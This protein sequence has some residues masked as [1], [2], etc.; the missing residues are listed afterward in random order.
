MSLS[1][2]SPH[3]YPQTLSTLPLFI[4]TFHTSTPAVWTT[5]RSWEES[6]CDED[7]EEDEEEEEEEEEEEGR[8]D[9]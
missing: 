1:P 4:D 7:E 5:Q 3:A 9:L 8:K 2:P 6:F